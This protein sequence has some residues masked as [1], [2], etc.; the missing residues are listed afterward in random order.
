MRTVHWW[1]GHRLDGSAVGIRRVR[2]GGVG[3]RLF[4]GGVG[5]RLGI[6]ETKLAL[7]WFGGRFSWILGW[8]FGIIGWFGWFGGAVAVVV[9]VLAEQLQG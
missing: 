4:G 9:L 8:F 3:I 5:I 6:I 1:I 2:G 7:A